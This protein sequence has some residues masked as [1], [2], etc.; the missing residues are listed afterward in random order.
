MCDRA[1]VPSSFLLER[2]CTSLWPH[3]AFLELNTRKRYYDPQAGLQNRLT[4][5][6]FNQSN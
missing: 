5:V 1:Q 6:Q 2:A 3:S 4:I